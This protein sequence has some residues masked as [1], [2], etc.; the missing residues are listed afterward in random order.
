MIF[1]ILI[2]RQ[3]FFIRGIRNERTV[4]D[5]KHIVTVRLVSGNQ[6]DI[7]VGSVCKSFNGDN[8]RFVGVSFYYFIKI[9]MIPPPFEISVLNFSAVILPL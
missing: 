2:L 1:K 4:H 7:A 6:A 5:M 3:I 9:Y 8:T